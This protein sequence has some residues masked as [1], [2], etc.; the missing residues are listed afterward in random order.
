MAS[1]L[2]GFLFE[3]LVL[4]TKKIHSTPFIAF[5]DPPEPLPSLCRFVK[6]LDVL[7][8]EDPRGKVNTHAPGIARIIRRCH[9]LK[10]HRYDIYP[11][12]VPSLFPA[13]L[14]HCG[15]S[16]RALHLNGVITVAISCISQL[17][18]TVALRLEYLYLRR[19]QSS[20]TEDSLPLGL[21]VAFPVLHAFGL[22]SDSSEIDTESLA[23]WFWSF[24]TLRHFIQ[25][26][27]SDQCLYSLPVFAQSR[28]TLTSIDVHCCSGKSDEDIGEVSQLGHPHNLSMHTVLICTPFPLPSN[29]AG[30]N[31]FQHTRPRP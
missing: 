31:A 27:P 5:M 15:H 29:R 9:N 12:Y 19:V 1:Y 26:A 25:T 11:S 23:Q 3:T 28:H 10:I 17:L 30:W 2:N 8:M 24:L 7:W 21:S 16:L 4:T 20:V 14:R 18:I 13:L 6:R 22:D